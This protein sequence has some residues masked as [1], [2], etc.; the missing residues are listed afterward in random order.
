[1]AEV[2]NRNRRAEPTT[3]KLKRRLSLTLT[4]PQATRTRLTSQLVTA[5]VLRTRWF[6]PTVFRRGARA[7]TPHC[8]L[9]RARKAVV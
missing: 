4:G 9:L 6:I 1:M 8:S 7:D 2:G 5:D 3:N